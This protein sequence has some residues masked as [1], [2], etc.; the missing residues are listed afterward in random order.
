M[1]N[2]GNSDLPGFRA[3]NWSW[4]SLLSSHGWPVIASAMRTGSAGPAKSKYMRVKDALE[5]I[6]SK[7]VCMYV[8]LYQVYC[9]TTKCNMSLCSLSLYGRRGVSVLCGTWGGCREREEV[10]SGVASTTR[11]PLWSGVCTVPYYCMHKYA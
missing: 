10:I 9:S 11:E 8:C 4:V 6:V 2:N 7:D 5:A 3:R 1:V